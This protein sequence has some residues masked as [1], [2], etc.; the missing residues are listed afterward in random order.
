MVLFPPFFDTGGIFGGVQIAF[1]LR[2]PPPNAALDIRPAP[3]VETLLLQLCAIACFGLAALLAFDSRFKRLQLRLLT[4]G[5]F[6][7]LALASATISFSRVNTGRGWTDVPL[8]F[9]LIPLQYPGG[10]YLFWLRVATVAFLT[11]AAVR[12][13]GRR[14]GAIPDRAVLAVGAAALMVVAISTV[15]AALR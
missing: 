6:V 2:P 7:A 5:A 3:A 11:F 12:L 8:I 13:A 15:R 14:A 1:A 9:C 10:Y 4:F